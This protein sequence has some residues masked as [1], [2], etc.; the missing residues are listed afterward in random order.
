MKMR[1]KMEK[2]QNGNNADGSAEVLQQT[3]LTALVSDLLQ[4]SRDDCGRTH[5][6]TNWME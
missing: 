2:L 3:T 4:G 5:R 6:N 1:M